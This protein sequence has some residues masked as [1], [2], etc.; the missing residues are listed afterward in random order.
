VLPF[1]VDEAFG[2]TGADAFGAVAALLAS[3]GFFCSGGVGIN[4]W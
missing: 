3:T 1:T 2:G 4:V